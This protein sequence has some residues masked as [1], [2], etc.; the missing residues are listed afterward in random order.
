M[1]ENPGSTYTSPEPGTFPKRRPTAGTRLTVDTGDC[2]PGPG[3]PPAISSCRSDSA[4]VYS[5][6]VRPPSSAS[7][8]RLPRFSKPGIQAEPIYTNVV[9]TFVV[10]LLVVVAGTAT[11]RQRRLAAVVNSAEQKHQ[12]GCL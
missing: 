12:V 1:A 5:P 11:Y 10:L 2:L 7:T 4:G 3:V 6:L 9:S 8:R